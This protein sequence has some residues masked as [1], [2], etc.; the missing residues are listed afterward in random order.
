MLNVRFIVKML[1]LMLILETLFMLVATGVAFYYGEGD[2][3]PLLLASGTMCSAG[4]IAYLAGINANEF[5]AGRREGMLTVAF[6]WIVLSFF[7]MLPFYWGGY[8]DNVTDAYFEAMSG[9]TTTGSTILADIE[10]LPHGILFW[11][12]LIQWEGGIG[13]VVF[14]VALMPILGGNAVIMFEEET[15]GFTHERFRPRVTQVAKRLW[16]VYVFLTLCNIGLY[17]LGPMNLF[18]AV[19]HGLTTISTGGFSTYNDSIGHF[20]SAYIEWVAIAFMFIGSLNMSLLYI[21]FNGHPERLWKDE[22]AHW[23]AGFVVV[24]SLFIGCWIY[25]QGYVTDP[26]YAI[27]TSVF[28]VV[29]L[30]ST[31]GFGT[32]DYTLWGPFVWLTVMMLM[33]VCGCAGSTSGGLK[34]GRFV[35][36]AKNLSNEFKKQVHPNAIIPVRINGHTLPDSVVHRVLAFVFAYLTL[37]VASC[38]ILTVDG[39]EFMDAISATLTALSNVGPGLGNLGPA[40]NFAEV[41]VISKWF[42]CFLMMTGRLEVFTVLTILLPGFWKR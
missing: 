19:C 36:L 26:T 39:M 20:D 24:A 16:G 22:E 32:D 6:I 11:R 13:V 28:Q 37:M 34:M 9:F 5:S 38:F 29:T 17:A 30:I 2:F 41:P 12:S 27:R 33:F 8:I 15:S 7:G 40:D 31:C 21:S 10:S 25:F 1:G 35:I 4:V 3:F 42:L 14:T 18:D 23:F